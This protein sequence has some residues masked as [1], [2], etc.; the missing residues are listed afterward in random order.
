MS[1]NDEAGPPQEGGRGQGRGGGRGRGRGGGGAGAGGHC[2]C[3][4]CGHKVPH[5]RGQPCNEQRCPECGA[6]MTRDIA[7]E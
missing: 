5:V 7:Q 6:T 2:V 1:Q 4:Q 3:P